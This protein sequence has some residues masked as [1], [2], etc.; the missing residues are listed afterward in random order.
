MKN[1]FCLRS[2]MLKIKLFSSDLVSLSKPSRKI[3]DLI[4]IPSRKTPSSGS[5]SRRNLITSSKYFVEILRRNFPRW[6]LLKTNS[7]ASG[8]I[9]LKIFRLLLWNP[10]K[11]L[12]Y[13]LY[14]TNRAQVYLLVFPWNLRNNPHSVYS[15]LL[16]LLMV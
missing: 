3:M 4:W 12:L 15:Q 10:R 1:I 2:T 7:P 11:T 16:I 8:L 14:L 13:Q 9:L 6:L 5:G